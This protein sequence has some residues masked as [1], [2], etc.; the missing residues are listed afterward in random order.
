MINSIYF[1]KLQVKW[2]CL[3]CHMKKAPEPHPAQLQSHAKEVAPLKMDTPTPDV[4][5]KKPH[6]PADAVQKDKKPEVAGKQDN[7]KTLAET[8]QPTQREMK[9]HHI[10]EVPKSESQKT[11]LQP[12]K[13]GFFGFGFGGARS[14]SPSPQPAVS[15]VSEKV[16]GF[17][18]S[19]L[20]SASNLISTAV[21]D[22]SSTTPSSSRKASTT[23]QM[24]NKTP[25]TSR[26]GSA[27]SQ[28]S[29]KVNTTP[30][31]SR[32]GSTV[33]QMSV[34]TTPPTSQKESEAVINSKSIENT[35]GAKI[36]V[37]EKGQETTKGATPQQQGR[38]QDGHVPVSSEI[39][40]ESRVRSQS[41]L[42]PPAASAVSG[43][44]LGFGSS[45]FSSAS[46]L[47]SSALD[48]PSTTPPTSRKG[49]TSSQLSAKTTTPPSSRKGSSVSQTS[50][51]ITTPPSSQKG[52]GVSQTS[53]KTSTPSASSKGSDVSPKILPSDDKKVHPENIQELIKKDDKK[54]MVSQAQPTIVSVTKNR[55]LPETTR[56]E[57]TKSFPKACP[58]CKVDLQKEP[59]NYNTCTECKNTVCNL[60]GFNPMPHE[61]E[62]SSLFNLNIKHLI[63]IIIIII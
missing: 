26:K 27:V 30:P 16:L 29:S 2:L 4:S 22:E 1:T 52:S 31:S 9:Q 3:A 51:K 19:F 6:L 37:A 48:E 20:S 12:D 33:S 50:D 61:T 53:L 24:S 15:A 11:D 57:P 5:Q 36:K 35:D 18:S 23:S 8:E 32:K 17:G 49:S 14:R 63:L 25:S 41:P 28:I 13:P 56:R 34:K 40:E 21:Q 10:A 55:D 46:N 47:I 38:T 7:K 44:V 58:L 43:K 42:L 54:A 62:V 39:P 60:C 59:P 45:L